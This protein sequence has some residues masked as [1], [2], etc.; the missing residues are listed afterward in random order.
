MIKYYN[1]TWTKEMKINVFAY[2]SNSLFNECNV[3]E[4]FTNTFPRPKC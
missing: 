2:W 4:T 3:F 1:M